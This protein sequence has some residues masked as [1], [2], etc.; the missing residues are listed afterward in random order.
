MSLTYDQAIAFLAAEKRAQRRLEWQTRPSKPVGQW[1]EAVSPIEVGGVVPQ[2]TRLILSWRAP[3]GAR[4]EKLGFVILFMAERV[5][6][7]DF[8]PDG[9]HTNKIGVE[10]P[11]FR[12]RIGPGTHVHTPSRDGLSGYAEPIADFPSFQALFEFGAMA[13]RLEVPGGFVSPPQVQMRLNL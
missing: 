2:Q 11:Y 12:K 7:V 13:C 5:Y 3:A 9:Q 6:G 8:D 1:Y 10:R 4:L